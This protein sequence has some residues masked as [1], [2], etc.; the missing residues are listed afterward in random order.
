M[1][2]VRTAVRRHPLVVVA[3]V[4][5]VVV[6]GMGA[7]G[8]DTAARWVATGF[9]VLVIVHTA[10]GMVRDILR[11]HYG[12][13]ILA[14]V[15]M[16]ATVSVGEYIAALII[17]VMLAGGAA[18]EEYAAARARASLTALLER[19]PVLAHR[20]PRDLS[21]AAQGE[22]LVEDVPIDDVEIGDVLLV[23]PSE[24]VP[25]NG[26]LLEE[27][28]TFDESSLTGESLPVVRALGE[29]V[30]SGA[31]NGSLGIRL[32]AT[33][34]AADSQ[35]QQILRLVA[36]AEES[37]P[38]TVR[39]ADRFAVPFTLVSLAIGGVAWWLSGDPVRFAEVMVLATPC[40]L[41]IAPP[42]AFLGGTSRAARAGII[43][44]G[45]ATLEGL[46]NARSVAF[47][48]TGTLSRGRPELARID[49]LPGVDPQ[50]LLRLA[51][52]AEQYSSH[53]LAQGVVRAAEERGLALAPGSH[54]EEHA[55]HGV[56]AL[57]AGHTVTVGKL[58]FVR[59]SDPGAFL[60]ELSPGETSVAVAV[61]GRFVGNLVL[62]DPLRPNAAATVRALREEAIE[63]I[64]MLTGD[65]RTT[66]YSLAEQ[67][68]I[69]DVHAEL[70]PQ[71]KVALVTSLPHRPVVMVGDGVNDAPVLAVAEVGIAMGARGST[72]ASE[73][74]DVVITRDDIGKVVQAIDIG[75]RTF[76]VALSAIWIG[77]TLSMGLMMVAAFGF[78][79]AIAGALTQEIIDLVAILYALLALRPGTA[80]P[81][82]LERAEPSRARVPA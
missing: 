30:L 56:S 65:N 52:S 39:V 33:S 76:R 27:E 19:A 22:A 36:Q 21:A 77:I 8:Q 43:V 3:L 74:A 12:L 78:I 59:E 67:A 45:G 7:A 28:A 72:A 34:K 50:E 49:A 17:V 62:V 37:K 82:V 71:D 10:V 32:Q 38:P 6:L 16:V 58:A 81:E 69:T 60:S 2:S 25:V 13:D 42:V 75:Q 48:K 29:Q 20:I 68:G 54:G 11:G 47:D 70:L 63:D 55:T 64:V 79:P 46:A 73:A 9:V 14:V 23:R 15:A 40:P 18:L 61:D 31:L 44:K 26:E 4:V 80:H 51:A 41:L 35:Y 53:V 66:A 1:D 24:V 57:V 5:L